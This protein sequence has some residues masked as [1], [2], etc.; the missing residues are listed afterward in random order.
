[1]VNYIGNPDFNHDS[2]P[3]TGVLV[4]NLGTPDAP[5]TSAL[6]HYLAEF[7]A[8]PRVVEIPKFIWWFVLHG[9]ILRT[10]PKRSAAIY[11]KIWTEAGSP[12]LATS[13]KQVAAIQ[14]FLDQHTTEKFHVE[15]AMRYGN[16]SIQSG[17]ETL[18][19]ANIKKIII[20]PLYPQYSASTT[21]STFDAV[22]NVLKT[23]RDIPELQIILMH[24]RK[25]LLN[26]GKKR[27]VLKNYCSHFMASRRLM[28]K[29][30]IRIF[31]SVTKQPDWSPKN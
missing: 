18:Q 11:R 30:V 28:S 8:D 2:D 31:T 27:A 29:R 20:L 12:L 26:I 17:L 22:A 13:K 16:P 1:M 24:W 3:C 14:T 5:T 7:L 25:V 10:R 19:R 23:W 21:A 6:R 15:L 9:F 4:T